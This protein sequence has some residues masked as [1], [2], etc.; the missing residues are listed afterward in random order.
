MRLILCTL[1]LLALACSCQYHSGCDKKIKE[2][3]PSREIKTIDM[4]GKTVIYWLGN[5]TFVECDYGG[6]QLLIDVRKPIS[7]EQGYC[8]NTGDPGACLKQIRE[9]K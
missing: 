8:N 3:Y 9:N 6:T 5:D 7:W 2:L 1:I 4:R